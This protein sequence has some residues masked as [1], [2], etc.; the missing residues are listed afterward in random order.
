MKFPTKTQWQKFFDVLSKRE[1]ILFIFFSFLFFSSLSFLICNFYF[2]NSKVVPAT[3]GVFIEGILEEPVFLNPIFAISQPD[4]DLVSLLYSPLFDFKDGNLE[5][6]LAEKYE[7]LE[8]GKVFKVELK[9]NIFWED[10]QRITADDVLFTVS[11]IQNVETKSPLRN[12][13]LGVN[14]EKISDSLLLFKLKKASFVFLENLT[15]KP[16]PKHYFE[17]ILPQN[18]AFSEKNLA[19][20]SSGPFKLE[21]IKKESG[22]KI[23]SVELVRNEKYF[24]KKPKIEKVIFL[25]FKKEKDLILAAKEGRIDGFLGK[26]GSE[27]EEFKKIK[28]QLPRYFA[29]FLNLNSKGLEEKEVREALSLAVDRKALLKDV[30]KNEGEIVYSPLLP[31]FYGFEKN[32][33]ENY[34]FEKAQT[35]LDES[36]FK[37]SE[38]RIREKVIKKEPS[39]QFK[40]DLRVGS[41]GKEVKELQKCLAKFP[42]I[43]PSRE[44]TGYFGNLTKKAVKAFQEKFK[45]DILKPFGLEEGTGEVKKKTREKLNEVCFERGEERIKLE[46]NLATGKDPL[47]VKTAE[48]IKESLEKLGVKITINK[49]DLEKMEREII[50]K[51]DYD[52]LLFGQIYGRILD[53]YPFWHSS[54][55]QVG[56]LNL[57][58]FK[59]E[60]LDKILIKERELIDPEKRKE[61]LKEFEKII[62]EEKPAIFLFNPDLNYFVSKNI[63]NV[64]G[65]EIFKIEERFSQI[66]DWYIKEK[67][68]FKI[69]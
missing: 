44:I 15:L 65:G 58:N 47:L 66:E 43:Y 31:S 16:I 49:Y 50:P 37:L 61:K 11:L 26:E 4:K 59:D 28:F 69:K 19:P 5:P 39:F 52:M 56:F 1:K 2:K 45:D 30:L 46:F 42:E 48:K 14:V 3:G 17:E 32:E 64:K 40:S 51:K 27:I 35:I 29:L 20:L 6:K 18:L 36:G 12:S 67:R 38:D 9:D 22:G 53:P 55:I 13:W 41:R 54:Q 10:G 8:G 23:F 34:N 62:L 63:K 21:K 33:I 25:K 57:S 60:K 24:G 7:I 68:V